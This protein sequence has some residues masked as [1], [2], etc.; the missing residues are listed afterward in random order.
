MNP[1]PK[2]KAEADGSKTSKSDRHKEAT[3]ARVR[4]PLAD[5]LQQLADTNATKFTEEV[6][7]AVR[8]YLERR[9]LWPPKR[10]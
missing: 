8:E 1:M 9:N 4:K 3:M 2:R 10:E 7:N 6:N 5:V